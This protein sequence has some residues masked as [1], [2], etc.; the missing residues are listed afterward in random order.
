MACRW[1]VCC[2]FTP[3][4]GH[5]FCPCQVCIMHSLLRVLFP[6]SIYI[7]PTSKHD[8]EEVLHNPGVTSI[9]IAATYTVLYVLV[10]Y[11]F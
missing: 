6:Y 1:I 3:G 4:V 5:N 8:R 11:Q 10:L 7:K 9:I 2:C